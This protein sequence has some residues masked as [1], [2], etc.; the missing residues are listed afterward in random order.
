MKGIVVTILRSP[1]PIA[2]LWGEDGLLIYNQ[3]Y[4]AIA[5]GRHPR[6]LGMPV[7]EAWPEVADFNDHVVRTVFGQG[8]TLSFKDQPLALQRPG[9]PER[10]WFNLD[11]SP[12]LDA[13]RHAARRHRH[14]GRDD[15][16]GPGRHEARG[17]ARAACGRCT[18]NRRA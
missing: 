3:G 2:T 17:R 16:Q 15:R 8:E 11:Y 12:V 9:R 6:V 7:R 4:S 13:R 18:S 1:L 10:A 14:R 5:G